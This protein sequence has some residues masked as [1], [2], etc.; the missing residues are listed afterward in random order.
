MF[1]NSEENLMDKLLHYSEMLEFVD[2]LLLFLQL[3]FRGK[4]LNNQIARNQNDLKMNSDVPIIALTRL[5]FA[6]TICLTLH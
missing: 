6:E 1:A 5:T 2:Y 4:T 3:Y